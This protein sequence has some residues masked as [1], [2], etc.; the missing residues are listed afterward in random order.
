MRTVKL[1]PQA[2]GLYP[3]RARQARGAVHVVPVRRVMPFQLGNAPFHPQRGEHVD[4]GLRV[5][6]EGIEQRSVPVEEYAFQYALSVH[7]HWL[8]PVTGSGGKMF[9]S[10]HFRKNKNSTHLDVWL[11]NQKKERG[12]LTPLSRFEARFVWS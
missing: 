9:S 10:F 2:V 12:S 11:S 7:G 6:F 5:G 3:F 8:H 4:V 1:H